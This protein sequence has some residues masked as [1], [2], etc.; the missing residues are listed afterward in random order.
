[1]WRRLWSKPAVQIGSKTQRG[2]IDPLFF[3]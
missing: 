2:S 1:M 3:R